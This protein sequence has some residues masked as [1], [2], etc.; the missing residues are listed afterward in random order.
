MGIQ[1]R[2]MA[3]SPEEAKAPVQS[4]KQRHGLALLMASFGVL[5]LVMVLLEAFGK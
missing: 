1:N 3:G 4:W 2:E 5:V